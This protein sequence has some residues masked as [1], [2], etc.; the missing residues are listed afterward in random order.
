[1]HVAW[2]RYLSWLPVFLVVLFFLGKLVI[3][4]VF[5]FSRVDVFVS[6]GI[7]VCQLIKPLRR[8]T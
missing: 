4:W 5:W 2:D 1:L 6:R 7:D 8:A 3:T